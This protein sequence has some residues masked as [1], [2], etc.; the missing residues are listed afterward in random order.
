LFLQ[1]TLDLFPRR[2]SKS[3][4]RTNNPAI[5]KALDELEELELELELLELLELPE[6]EAVSESEVD[7]EVSVKGI[8][9]V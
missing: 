2:Y 8:S 1:S 6:A 7:C 4:P 5:T 3:E 9:I